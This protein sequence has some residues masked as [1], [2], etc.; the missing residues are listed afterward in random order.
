MPEDGAIELS[1]LE[2]VDLLQEFVAKTGDLG[3]S[4]DSCDEQVSC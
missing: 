3:E 2:P 4:V 1:P